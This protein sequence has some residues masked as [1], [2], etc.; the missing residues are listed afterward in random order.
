MADRSRRRAAG[1]GVT[2]QTAGRRV[3]VI[4]AG[5]NGLVAAIRL[6]RTGIDV[7]VLEQG[8]FPGGGLTSAELTLPGFVHDP[9]AGFF[10]LAVVSPALRQLPLGRYGVEWITPPTVMAHPFEDGSAIALN[11]DP[12]ATA[13]SLEQ[14][15]PG[16]GHAWLEMIRQ[17]GPH[18]SEL[19]AAGM[20]PI[21][22]VRTRLRLARKLGTPLL[23]LL[24]QVT[25]SALGMGTELFRDRRPTAWFAGSVCHG[26][27]GPDAP[28]SAGLA[29][30]LLFLGQ[31]AG[32]PL[33]RGGSGR[34]TDALTRC[35]TDAGGEVRCEADV[36]AIEVAGGRANGVRLRGGERLPADAVIA[37][38]GPR[39]LLDML[40][41]TLR[42]RSVMRPLGKWRYGIG[43]FKLDLAL[44]GPVPWT[45]PECRNAGVVHLCGELEELVEAPREANSGV[46]PRKPAMV[47][48]Q[49]SLH[50][51][52]RAP[53]GK[54]TLYAYTRV[55]NR[56]GLS[57]REIAERMERRI[58]RF[59]PGFRSLIIERAVRG[60]TEIEAENPAMVGGDLASGSVRP[61][62]LLLRPSPRL[63]RGRT[64]VPGL[65]L[66][67]GSV[68]PGP[69][70][71][72]LSGDYAAR[73]VI[74]GFG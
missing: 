27:L 69:G 30:A 31:T 50:D 25:G 57:D 22:S 54:H 71:H 48:G 35:L 39:P 73:A 5:H 4:G 42:D 23:G 29:F 20:A 19:I 40:P 55:P 65:F 24:R 8:R 2:G 16:A 15:A 74:A 72:G 44:R 7:T 43:T 11:L 67:G 38:V 26:D 28:A 21:P 12:A 64:P 62:Q 1:T 58:E 14:A 33:V 45:N 18:T 59:A 56:P 49:Q 47:I 17:L 52:A 36:A 51:P 61:D 60:P 66:A 63:S 70:V 10:P 6:A 37:T 41:A 9:H 13:A 34:L 3:V 32:W 46:V 68:H 53:N